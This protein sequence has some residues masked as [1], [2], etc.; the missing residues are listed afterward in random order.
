MRKKA[1]I[2]AH[3]QYIIGQISQNLYSAYLE[4][5]GTQMNGGM[6]NPGHPTADKMGLRHDMID[7]L[8]SAKV[9]AIR[10]PGGNFV[11]G[12]EWKDSIGPKSER[13]AHLDLAW[14]QIYTNEVGHDEFLTWAELCGM[15]PMYTINLGTGDL[16]DAIHIIEYSNHKGDTY[17]SD[18]RRKNGH[19][20]P[21]GVKKWY[22]GNEMDG[23]WQIG[24]WERDPRGYGRMAR[25]VSKAMKLV[26]NTVQTIACVSCSPFLPH[27]P[28]W[29]MEVLEECYEVVDYIS[30]HHYHT[31]NGQDMA[32][33]MAAGEYYENYIKT[34][35]ALC[36]FMQAKLASPKKMML[37]IDEYGSHFGS[38]NSMTYQPLSHGRDAHRL[39][40]AYFNYQRYPDYVK[41]DPSHMNFS[42]RP[43]GGDMLNALTSGSTILS[44]LRHADRVK[45]GCMTGGLAAYA[46]CDNAHVWRAGIFYVMQ[47]LQTYGRGTSLQLAVDCDTYDVPS[48]A[49]DDVQAYAELEG[50]KYI[51][52]AGALDEENG[53]LNIFV[54]N[55]NWEEDNELELDVSAFDGYQFVAHSQLYSEDLDA[56]NSYENPDAV[57]PTLN[58]QTK[59]EGGKLTA[60]VKKLS[61]NVFQFRK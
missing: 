55:R 24:T 52:A 5:I 11:S 40:G 9:P 45:I 60:T 38:T 51:D 43:R 13:K 15:E 28:Q 57:V 58:T 27:Y 59:V 37:S 21:Y 47:D 18:L 30:M 61:W 25:E 12:W 33:L 6:Y 44:F 1:L 23:P 50:V 3:P 10:L 46:A 56:Y 2:I 54:I 16:K 17:W 41:Y 32:S 19:E 7:A 36:D 20:K 35:I 22:L 4:P 53:A 31:A 42:A 48:Y 49:I 39:A 26:D 34:E 8:K 14:K 29:D